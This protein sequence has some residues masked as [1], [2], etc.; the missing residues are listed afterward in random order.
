MG[1]DRLS[2][3]GDLEREAERLTAERSSRDGDPQQEELGL[4]SL[5]LLEAHSHASFKL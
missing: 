5:P 2:E 3:H 4:L 1:G